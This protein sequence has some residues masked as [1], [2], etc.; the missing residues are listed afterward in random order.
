[1]SKMFNKTAC[2]FVDGFIIKDDE[3]IA[4]DPEIIKSLNDIEMLIQQ[5]EYVAAQPPAAPEPT[6]KGFKRESAFATKVG[7]AVPTPALDA[8]VAENKKVMKELDSVNSFKKISEMAEH[9]AKL[10]EFCNN[11]R[12]VGDTN[13]ICDRID[14]PIIGNPLELDVPTL[15]DFFGQI[16]DIDCKIVAAIEDDDE[17]ENE[18]PTDME[19]VAE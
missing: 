16:N 14:T 10:V 13:G 12:F 3:I 8:L 19:E 15:Y 9:F 11:P 7:F 5:H 18:E 6:L 2:E 1:M 17:P 4:I